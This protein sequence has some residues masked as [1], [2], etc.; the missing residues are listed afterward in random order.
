[1]KEIEWLAGRGYNTL[2]VSFP[3]EFSGN[4]DKARG[5]FLLVL[6]E[7]LTDPILTGREELGFSKIYCNL[8]EAKLYKDKPA[9]INI[10]PNWLHVEY[11]IIFLMSSCINATDAAKIA[12]IEPT[13]IIK[14][15]AKIE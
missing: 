13:K 12:V 9:A 5:N 4:K 15:D 10:K 11:A 14:F 2:G 7:N 1:M 6:W 3:V 8:P